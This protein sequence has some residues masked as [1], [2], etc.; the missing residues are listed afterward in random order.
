[1]AETKAQNDQICAVQLEIINEPVSVPN[2][3]SAP[4]MCRPSADIGRWLA[5]ALVGNRSAVYAP[6]IDRTLDGIRYFDSGLRDS[7]HWWRWLRRDVLGAGN[8]RC[9]S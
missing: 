1:M 3:G 2:G 8:V 6:S 4:W 7:G 5:P 9:R